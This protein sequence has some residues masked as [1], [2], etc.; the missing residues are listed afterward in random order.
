MDQHLEKLFVEWDKLQTELIIPLMGENE[1]QARL[2]IE[3]E[4]G[5]SFWAESALWRRREARRQW[6]NL[7][8]FG[9]RSVPRAKILWEEF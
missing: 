7:R 2:A 3:K 9:C 6:N 8:Y 1:E 4:A 5:G